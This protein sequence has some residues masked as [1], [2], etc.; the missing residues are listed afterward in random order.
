MDYQDEQEKKWLKQKR[1]GE[2]VIRVRS[3]HLSDMSQVSDEL[4]EQGEM[5]DLKEAIGPKD[6]PGIETHF[7]P[8]SLEQRTKRIEQ[9][10]ER[11]R[12]KK[13]LKDKGFDTTAICACEY[14][15]SL[16]RV[17]GE[18]EY[19]TL[20]NGEKLKKGKSKKNDQALLFEP[21]LASAKD[22]GL[23]ESASKANSSQLPSLSNQVN[24][25]KLNQTTPAILP[26]QDFQLDDNS[27]FDKQTGK[28]PYVNYVNMENGA[29]SLLSS[30]DRLPAL[31]QRVPANLKL[32][33]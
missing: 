13:L 10:R 7:E 3:L 15:S 20:M 6:F 5:G 25:L 31:N 14:K 2:K 23:S 33:Y 24:L 9:A 11:L 30:S 17:L 18:E 26:L 19:K 4:M 29:E 1:L 8:L 32:L 27:I 12:V 28:Q 16:E 21:V 22:V